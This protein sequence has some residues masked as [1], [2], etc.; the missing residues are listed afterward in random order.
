MKLSAII[1]RAVLAGAVFTALWAAWLLAF[2]PDQSLLSS[3]FNRARMLQDKHSRLR[4]TDEVN[5]DPL[6]YPTEFKVYI[7]PRP[8]PSPESTNFNLRN[9]ECRDN[10]KE[11]RGTTESLCTCGGKPCANRVDPRVRCTCER[12][13]LHVENDAVVVRTPALF[14]RYPRAVYHRG[15]GTG[16]VQSSP[17]HGLQLYFRVQWRHCVV[18]RQVVRYV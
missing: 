15:G 9:C 8:S 2:L 18:V 7:S 6:Q 3:P 4:A 17:P 16:R 12:V 10:W 11:L 1:G 13:A 14:A 5:D